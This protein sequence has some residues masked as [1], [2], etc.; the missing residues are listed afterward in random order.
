MKNSVI[1]I[2]IKKVPA[3]FNFQAIYHQK[4]ICDY[5]GV[6][7]KLSGVF[8]DV[9]KSYALFYQAEIIFVESVLWDESI[10]SLKRS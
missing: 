9:V 8:I 5:T 7:N 3:G 2:T 10:L 4:V 1:L 6:S